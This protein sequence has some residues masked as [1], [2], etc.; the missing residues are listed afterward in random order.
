[1]H[2]GHK[3]ISE[4]S[5]GWDRCSNSRRQRLRLEKLENHSHPPVSQRMLTLGRV[6]DTSSEA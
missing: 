6:S 3:S 5:D 2:M 1:M 4:T